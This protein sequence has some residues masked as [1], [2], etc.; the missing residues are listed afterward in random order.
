MNPCPGY[1]WDEN[2]PVGGA[3]LLNFQL[4]ESFGLCGQR[5]I[6]SG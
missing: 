5:H 6:D 3:Y 4:H 2:E 1:C